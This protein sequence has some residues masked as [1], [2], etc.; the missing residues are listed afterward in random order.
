MDNRSHLQQEI[1][2]LPDQLIDQVLAY[3]AALKKSHQL[4]RVK[5]T[6]SP[7]T[8]DDQ[9][10]DNLSQFTLDFMEERSQPELPKVK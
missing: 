5:Q 9:W 3:I 4:E 6:H 10:W 7:V 8:L 2:I 1:N